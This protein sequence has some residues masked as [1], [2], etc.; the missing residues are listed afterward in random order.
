[1]IG[2]VRPPAHRPTRAGQ[3]SHGGLPRGRSFCTRIRNVAFCNRARSLYALLRDGIIHAYI[4]VNSTTC[5]CCPHPRSTSSRS[6]RFSG[7]G[8]R[9]PYWKRVAINRHEFHP[10]FSDAVL[11]ARFAGGTG[12]PSTACSSSPRATVGSVVFTTTTVSRP[13]AGVPHDRSAFLAS[14]GCLGFA[15]H[16]TAATSPRSPVTLLSLA[17]AVARAHPC[18][19]PLEAV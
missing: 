13:V 6:S 18:T 1:M 3:N 8:A 2:V 11:V 19:C 5:V 10:K 16:L 17:P 7:G 4:R 15:T 9:K 14:S 12:F